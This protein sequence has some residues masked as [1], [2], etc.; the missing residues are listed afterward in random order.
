LS[1][2][3]LFIAV[4]GNI[5]AGKT[6]LTKMLSQRYGWRAHYEAV[7]D[8][9]YLSDFYTDMQRWSFS[10]QIFFLNNRFRAHQEVSLGSDSAIQ[11]RSIYEDANIFARNLYEQ[12][13]MEERDYRNYLDIYNTMSQYL[14]PPDL[15]VYLRKSIPKLKERIA[16]RGR[17]YEKEIPDSYLVN[18]NRYYDDWMSR[19]NNG[20]KL[21][22]ETDDLD[23][24]N[25]Q[26]DFEHVCELILA[27]L[28]QPDL[29]LGQEK[30]RSELG[31]GDLVE[32]LRPASKAQTAA[33]ELTPTKMTQGENSSSAASELSATP[34]QRS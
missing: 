32:S 22:I 6:T 12:G 33:P 26:D 13:N 34:V 7:T 4:A 16:M 30:E 1:T 20:R 28:D 10:L 23:Y 19:Y 3:K 11:D 27:Q 14:S 24:L 5:G 2:Q 18:L 15:V 25:D 8:N 17:D 29:F 9:P 31:S 21:I